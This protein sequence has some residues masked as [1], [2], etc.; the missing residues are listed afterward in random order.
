MDLVPVR[1]LAEDEVVANWGGPELTHPEQ[2]PIISGMRTI[3]L[4]RDLA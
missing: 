3:V 1:P 2:C 4:H